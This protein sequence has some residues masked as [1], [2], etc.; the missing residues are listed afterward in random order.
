M[1]DGV[2]AAG[3][4]LLEVDVGERAVWK[5]PSH[6][7]RHDPQFMV[8]GV[9]TLVRWRDGAVA[10]RLGGELESAPSPAAA[11]QLVDTFVAANS[12]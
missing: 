6:P 9:P 5:S 11:R 4:H 1:R 2:A 7:L 10:A 3:A 8:S 12:A